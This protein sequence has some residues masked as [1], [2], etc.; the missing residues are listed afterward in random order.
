MF[1]RII[2]AVTAVLILFFNVS[3]AKEN[4]KILIFSKVSEEAYTHESIA[5]GWDLIK[6]VGGYQGWTVDATFDASAFTASNLA[7]YD[8]VMFLNTAGD[9]LDDD[10]QD[11]FENY[12]QAGGG[13]VGSHA[14]TDTEFDWP[15]Y[16]ELVGAHFKRHPPG[17]QWAK[18]VPENMGHPASKYLLEP[19]MMNGDDYIPGMIADEWYEFLKNP[20]DRKGMTVMLA[21]DERSYQG[22]EMGVDHPAAWAHEFD[23]GRAFYTILGHDFPD[24]HFDHP[25]LVSHLVGAIE[26]AA[27]DRMIE[28]GLIVDLDADHGLTMEDGSSVSKWTNQVAD[29]TAQDFIKRD[30][31]RDVA[32]SGRPALKEN[33]AALNGHNSLVFEKQELVNMD[34]D[35]FDHLT[36]GSGYTWF[37]LITPYIQSDGLADVNMFIGNLRNGG[38]YD[39]LWGG[40][41]DNNKFWAGTRSGATFGR[42]NGNNPK[43]T[44]PML[45]KGEYYMVAARMGAGTNRVNVD[46]FVGNAEI[47]ASREI[48][49]NVH[50]NPSKMAVGQERDAIEHPGAESIDGEIARVLIYD[51]PLDDSEMD[52]MFNLLNNI[53]FGK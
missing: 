36:Q 16:D 8:V 31:G 25:F 42:F 47:L 45:K 12:I 33:V 27:G 26:W 3:F 34:E 19:G 18:V 29:F 46:V 7:K 51:R 1:T 48:E 4:I 11:A 2:A 52:D 44:G 17:V 32:G 10:Q 22:G 24:S 35:A 28:N 6:T 40:V 43:V 53:Y 14:A 41:E 39:G 23:G 15:W 37:A 9:I 13:F 49:V 50:G 5:K 21:V 20:R 30:E 38:M